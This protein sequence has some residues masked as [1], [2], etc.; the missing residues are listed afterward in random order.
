MQQTFFS[1][2]LTAK[3]TKADLILFKSVQN[4]TNCFHGI[5]PHEKKIGAVLR[6]VNCFKLPN[7]KTFKD[8]FNNRSV[9]KHAFFC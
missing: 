4:I 9:F 1:Q 5:L 8:S 7:V 6:K 2:V 3:L